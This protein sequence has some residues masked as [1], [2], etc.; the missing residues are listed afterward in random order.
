[1]VLKVI[2][3]TTMG[4]KFITSDL[5][6][7]DYKYRYDTTRSDGRS[8]DNLHLPIYLLTHL[9]TCLLVSPRSPVTIT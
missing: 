4:P 9:L 2:I 1:M 5:S 6:I 7:G 8:S 3:L